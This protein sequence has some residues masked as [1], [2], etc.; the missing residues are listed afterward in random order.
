MVRN[1]C[2]WQVYLCEALEDHLSGKYVAP[3]VTS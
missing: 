3:Y 1:S 2:F